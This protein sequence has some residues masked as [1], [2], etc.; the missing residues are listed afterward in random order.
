MWVLVGTPA[1]TAPRTPGPFGEGVLCTS[2]GVQALWWRLAYAVII[3]TC[4]AC[5]KSS[6]NPTAQTVATVPEGG[7]GDAG[8]V[9]D[10]ATGDTGPDG[11]QDSAPNPSSPRQRSTVELAHSTISADWIVARNRLEMKVVSGKA[12]REEISL[13]LEICQNQKDR[14]C[15]KECRKQLKVATH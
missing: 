15:Q 3:T 9:M 4:A 10:S 5:S 13:L 11:G 7:S 8:S 2:A 1:A 12:S 6:E 14:L